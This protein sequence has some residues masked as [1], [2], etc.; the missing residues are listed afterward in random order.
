MKKSLVFLLLCFILFSCK[1]EQYISLSNTSIM[2]YYDDEKK[3]TLSY[4]SDELANLTYKFTTSDTNIATVSS[5]GLV[6]GVSIG[7]AIITATS[8]NGEYSAQCTVTIIPKY[9]FYTEPY[10]NW[11]SSKEDVKDWEFRT[12]QSETSTMITFNGEYSYVTEVDYSFED[13]TLKSSL[14]IFDLPSPIV[15]NGI[16][17]YLLE[18]YV[19]D[20]TIGNYSIFNHRSRNIGCVLGV[21]NSEIVVGYLSKSQEK[22]IKNMDFKNI[23][24]KNETH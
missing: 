11:G 14:V 8:E 10:M 2:M 9:T 15:E 24:L 23:D 7:T 6:S 18:R 19:Y 20:T 16:T 22:N 1:K 12:I 3:L 5:S 13:S 4:S 21:Q 17:E